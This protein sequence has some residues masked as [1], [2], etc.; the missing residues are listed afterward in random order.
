M[1]SGLGSASIKV[2]DTGV[3]VAAMVAVN[4]TGDIWDRHTGK[5]IAVGARGWCGGWASASDG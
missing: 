1:K 3:V 5:V 2:G 4:A